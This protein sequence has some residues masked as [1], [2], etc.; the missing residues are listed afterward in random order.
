MARARSH[1]PASSA[2]VSWMDEP[3]APAMSL[4]LVVST[5]AAVVP[6]GERF[7]C[8]ATLPSTMPSGSVTVAVSAEPAWGA[9]EL[10]RTTPGSS[11]LTTEMVTW[12]ESVAPSGSA[13]VTV[14][15]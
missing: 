9:S 1:R 6:S 13:A 8:Q 15:V 12:M 10:R 14:T 7:H 3:V 2:S 4:K 11:T 5:S